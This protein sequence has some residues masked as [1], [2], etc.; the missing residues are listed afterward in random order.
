MFSR[1]INR[2]RPISRAVQARG[3]NS[4]TCEHHCI[5]SKD[6]EDLKEHVRR[7]FIPKYKIEAQI[8]KLEKAAQNSSD[9]VLY[10]WETIQAEA[11]K[12]LLKWTA[13]I[14]MLR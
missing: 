10:A 7:H 12:D 1:Q 8:K 3:V 9:G 4:L 11:L 14:V 5:W 2:T 6:L 13:D